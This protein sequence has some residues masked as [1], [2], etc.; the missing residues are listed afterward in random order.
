MTTANTT[1]TTKTTATTSTSSN[2][3][4]HIFVSLFRIFL[5]F[6]LQLQVHPR[7]HRLQQLQLAQV[8]VHQQAPLQVVR[9]QVHQ[10][11]PLQPVQPTL[12]DTGI[13]ENVDLRS[14]NIL[15]GQQEYGS[16]H[17]NN[18][19]IIDLQSTTGQQFQINRDVNESFSTRDLVVAMNI[20]PSN[21]SGLSSPFGIISSAS[22]NT[23]DQFPTTGKNI[24]IVNK[25]KRFII[26]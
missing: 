21:Q 1:T 19:Y 18:Y 9:A 3:F 2:H 7:R 13:E 11:V 15:S 22:Q 10:L 20:S 16:S 24:I 4:I 23:S 14:E 5:I 6:K 8:R 26:Q 17:V 12:D 25:S